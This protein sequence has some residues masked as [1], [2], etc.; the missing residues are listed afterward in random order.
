M[1]ARRLLSQPAPATEA[2]AVPAPP[3]PPR[4]DVVSWSVTRSATP[5]SPS[6]APFV[7]PSTSA[8]WP[9]QAA[10]FGRRFSTTGAQPAHHIWC[11]KPLWFR[12]APKTYPSPLRQ[13]PSSASCLGAR[14][15]ARRIDGLLIVRFKRPL[16]AFSWRLV[17]PMT[18]SPSQQAPPS[19]SP[20]NG[21]SGSSLPPWRSFL[22]TLN[23]RRDPGYEQRMMQLKSESE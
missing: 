17:T 8:N 14:R 19:S 5:P 1:P 13:R 2:L 3:W 6:Q 10:E 9:K 21:V 15:R 7:P 18:P 22:S 23:W 20:S 12:H 16:G 4:P 11:P